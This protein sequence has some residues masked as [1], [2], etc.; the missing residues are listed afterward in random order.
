MGEFLLLLSPT[1]LMSLNYSPIPDDLISSVRDS[2]DYERFFPPIDRDLH[3]TLGVDTSSTHCLIS[4]PLAGTGK[5]NS[6]K[7][8]TYYPSLVSITYR[9]FPWTGVSRLY[10]IPSTYLTDRFVRL[11]F[12]G[13]L[14]DFFSRLWNS[15]NMFRFV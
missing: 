15:S 14:V 10:W 7:S 11:L 12:R 13:R 9:W 4:T 8:K 1:R 3:E 5:A 6:T 2:A